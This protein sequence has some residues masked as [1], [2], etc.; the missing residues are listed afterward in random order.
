L[1]AVTFSRVFN[2]FALAAAILLVGTAPG[3]AQSLSD[4]SLSAS[5]NWSTGYMGLG[6][7][8][9]RAIVHRRSSKPTKSAKAEPRAARRKR[10]AEAGTYSPTIDTPVFLIAQVLDP[11][12]TNVSTLRLRTRGP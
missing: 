6:G 9:A 5:S 8:L 2:A 12:G 4:A 3:M 7:N 11:T 10:L 1:N